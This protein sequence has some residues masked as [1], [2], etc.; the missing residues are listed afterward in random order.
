[1]PENIISTSLIRS[2]DMLDNFINSQQLEIL[3]NTKNEEREYFV[4]ITN[5]LTNIINKMPKTKE[6]EEEKDPLIQLHYF[7]GNMDWMIIEKSTE[8]VQFDAY[9]YAN[10]GY[11]YEA[12]YINIQE[13][14]ENGVEL[15]F[16]FEPKPISSLIK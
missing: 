10:L 5:N 7:T 14:I 13:L 6:T 8:D 4:A 12:G 2:A 11:G 16:H 1:M 9:G 15:D 3:N